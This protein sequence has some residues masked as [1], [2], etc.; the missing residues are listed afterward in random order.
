MCTMASARLCVRL[1]ALLVSLLPRAPS[2]AASCPLD[3]VTFLPTAGL[4]SGADCSSSS[5]GTLITGLLC[6][7]TPSCKMVLCHG[8]TDTAAACPCVYCDKITAFNG[9]AS[10]QMFLF[11]GQLIG[12]GV[13]QVHLPRGLEAG[14]F[15]VLTATMQDFIVALSLITD[16]GDVAFLLEINF[17]SKTA[18]SNSVIGG[19]KGEEI[20]NK[21][22]NDF[23]LEK[24]DSVPL[25][26]VVG[27][28]GFKLY[29]YDELYSTFPLR[30]SSVNSIYTIEISSISNN[31]LIL[32]CYM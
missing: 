32:A 7:A 9:S 14:D 8:C 2:A 13:K 1:L 6:A 11:R 15:L 16:A 20:P 31:E 26:Y 21:D 29:V 4:A 28:S 3:L 27:E 24:S 10:D 30:V 23:V 17:I 18:K 5:E 12:Q 19:V 22:G 25:K